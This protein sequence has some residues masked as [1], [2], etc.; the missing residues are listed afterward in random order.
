MVGLSSA[1]LAGGQATDFRFFHL[2]W[3]GAHCTSFIFAAVGIYPSVPHT[4]SNHRTISIA[5]Q[6]RLSAFIDE[7][8]R[9]LKNR[10]DMSHTTWGW[11]ASL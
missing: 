1:M 6:E 11:S 5:Q 9:Q 10:R 2:K 3:G 8:G 7:L 4:L